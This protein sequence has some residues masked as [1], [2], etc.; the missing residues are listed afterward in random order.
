MNIVIWSFDCD[1]FVGHRNIFSCA[2]W[3]ILSL[4]VFDKL[5][6]S[7]GGMPVLFPSSN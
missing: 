4:E 2:L 6:S 5:L 3:A 7:L 1:D